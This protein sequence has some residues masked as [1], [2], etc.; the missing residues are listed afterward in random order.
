MNGSPRRLLPK[1]LIKGCLVW[2][3]H[4]AIARTKGVSVGVK[5]RTRLERAD[6]ASTE[7]TKREPIEL[8]SRGVG[9][10]RCM[11]HAV[12]KYVYLLQWSG[13]H[14]ARLRRT[15][16]KERASS[17]LGLTTS[18]ASNDEQFWFVGVTMTVAWWYKIREKSS[19]RAQSGRRNR[20]SFAR[21]AIA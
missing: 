5:S 2:L 15:D 19:V 20:D 9:V 7:G 16:E 12:L 10:V 13:W 1:P 8:E 21:L 14:F 4:F 18:E 6:R 11:R 3:L 17:W